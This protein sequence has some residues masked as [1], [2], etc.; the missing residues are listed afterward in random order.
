[1]CTAVSKFEDARAGVRV[2]GPRVRIN[3]Y[4][5]RKNVGAGDVS[6]FFRECE[7][8]RVVALKL[9]GEE[10]EGSWSAVKVYS[11]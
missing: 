4:R 1:M 10:K 9:Y 3:Y 2:Y 6:I 11:S 5:G 7:V 8:R